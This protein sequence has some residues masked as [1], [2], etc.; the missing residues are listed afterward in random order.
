M[1]NLNKKLNFYESK[2]SLIENLDASRKKNE[3]TVTNV[4]K[5]QFYYHSLIFAVFGDLLKFYIFF[6]VG[7]IS[8]HVLTHFSSIFF[9]TGY[10]KKGIVHNT[11]IL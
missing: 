7:S 3:K 1:K 4:I 8:F 2:N 10:F 6:R 11:L 9:I 5:P